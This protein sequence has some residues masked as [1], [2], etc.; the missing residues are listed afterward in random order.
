MS[1][2]PQISHDSREG[3]FKNVHRGH[4][5]EASGSDDFG[6]LFLAPGDSAPPTIASVPANSRGRSGSGATT[7]CLLVALLM[8]A[9]ST[10]V[11]AGLMP[12][13]KHG[14]RGVCAFAAAGSKFEGTGFE[15]LHIVQ[16]QVAELFGGCS[17]GAA[18]KGLSD[19]ET[20][21]A[22]PFLGEPVP[23]PGDLDWTEERFDG[24]GIK[25]TL[26]EDLRKPVCTQAI[27]AK[28][29]S[30]S[31]C[32]A[33]SSHIVFV[34]LYVLQVQGNRVLPG[35]RFVYIADPM[36]G[37]V[38][39][40]I[41]LVWQLVLSERKERERVSCQPGASTPRKRTNSRQCELLCTDD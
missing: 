32:M 23:T 26:G 12:H 2:P 3:W 25:V 10:C 34:A 27:S 38:D 4:W 17:T 6:G 24:F 33:H 14:G 16:T 28:C 21:D 31:R 9:F 20:G 18:R 29:Y 1:G 7:G 8:A 40:P 37:Q 13:A 19:C 39:L 36:G 30:E 22:V 15:K 41:L 11:N 35:V 5:K